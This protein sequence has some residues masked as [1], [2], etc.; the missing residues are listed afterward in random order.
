MHGDI[1][2]RASIQLSACGSPQQSLSFCQREKGT[3]TARSRGTGDSRDVSRAESWALLGQSQALA[4]NQRRQEENPGPCVQ[5]CLKSK[6]KSQYS[7]FQG[8]EAW[9]QV[10]GSKEGPWTPDLF[11]LQTYCTL[12]LPKIP[13]E[14][15][16]H[17]SALGLRVTDSVLPVLNQ[18][19]LDLSRRS[20][21]G[22]EP[23]LSEDWESEE[24]NAQ[25]Q[26]NTA[27]TLLQTGTLE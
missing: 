14:Y 11:L 3:F 4:Q 20:K 7:V 23:H 17:L 21:S 1:C 27:G 12:L 24:T 15:S 8:L 6:T 2:L 9:S 25:V 18:N 19:T 26:F 13:L 5:R 10:H 16:L 22:K